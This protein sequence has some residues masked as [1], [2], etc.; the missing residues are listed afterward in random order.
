M[1][2]STDISKAAAAL[3]K[4]GGAAGTGKAKARSKK[5]YSEAGKKSGEV[6]RANAERRKAL[7]VGRV[8]LPQHIKDAKRK[9]RAAENYRMKRYGMTREQ[10]K[11]AI[12]EAATIP[13]QQDFKEAEAE[14]ADWNEHNE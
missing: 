11:D 4:K 3:G 6:R 9:A 12:R 2:K 7:G 1:S 14:T 5:H 13:M 8:D 10:A